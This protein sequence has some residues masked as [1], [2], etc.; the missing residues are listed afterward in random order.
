[1]LNII[2]PLP[3]EKISIS[4]CREMVLDICKK[5]NLRIGKF[6]YDTFGSAESIQVLKEQGYNADAL[7]VDRTCDPY[8][9]LCDLFYEERIKLYDY[10]VFNREFFNLIYYRSKG[11][12]D[13][14]ADGSKDTSD[15][16]AAACFNA[17]NSE[18]VMEARRKQDV[19]NITSWL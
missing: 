9:S 3:P 1:M 15:S 6:T 18:S 13:H 2:P 7:S 4:K 5:F 8:L 16:V 17:L 10:E 19:L 14:P 11:K 12:I